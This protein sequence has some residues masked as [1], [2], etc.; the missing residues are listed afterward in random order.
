MGFAISIL[1]PSGFL[2]Q[3]TGLELQPANYSI[4]LRVGS[5]IRTFGRPCAKQDSI[6]M[7]PSRC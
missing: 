1:L 4:G 3:E 6:P 2:P 5:I 7:I